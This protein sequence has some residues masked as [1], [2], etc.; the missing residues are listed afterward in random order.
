MRVTDRAAQERI[1]RNEDV[2]RKANEGIGEVAS[3]L[4]FEG[5][6]V[7]FICECGD[8]TCREIIRLSFAEYR[9]A[10][11]NPRRFAT[12]PG[13]HTVAPDVTS[14]VAEGDRYLLVEKLDHAGEVAA[15]LAPKEEGRV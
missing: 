12:A 15:R 10:R 7:P 2:F 8:T 9:E 11:A 4:D 6:L 5:D 1:A 13:H 3:G 14:V